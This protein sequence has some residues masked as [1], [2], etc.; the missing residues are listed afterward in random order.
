MVFT[1]T[2]L[3]GRGETWNWK[4]CYKLS[5]I[6]GLSQYMHSHF[7]WI[8]NPNSHLKYGWNPTN[9]RVKHIH[10]LYLLPLKIAIYH[11][12]RLRP[13][14]PSLP[15]SF[16]CWLELENQWSNLELSKWL[17]DCNWSSIVDP[18]LEQRKDLWSRLQLVWMAKVHCLCF[19]L[20]GFICKVYYNYLF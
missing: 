10:S 4:L 5:T 16:E 15:L 12:R 3:T 19:S 8:C 17:G 6:P 13:L 11:E 1:P 2:N 7:P 18:K 9:L 14:H 20:E